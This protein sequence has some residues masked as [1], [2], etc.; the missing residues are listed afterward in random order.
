[1]G[2]KHNFR[3]D[4]SLF[5]HCRPQNTGGGWE[6]GVGGEC[7]HGMKWKRSVRGGG[8]GIKNED[9]WGKNLKGEEKD[10]EKC[11]KTLKYLKIAAS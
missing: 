6:E 8:P 2:Y 11:M 1:M 9:L 7:P 5:P 3:G 4:S 10:G